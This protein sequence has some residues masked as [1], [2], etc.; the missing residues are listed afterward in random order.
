MAGVAPQMAEKIL[1][2]LRQL[3]DGR[4]QVVF[5]EHDIE[6]VRQIA[7]NVIVMDDGKIITQ[8]PPTEVLERPEIMEAYLG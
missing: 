7:D 4:R 2:L 6:A 5:I 3:R 1:G 8:G